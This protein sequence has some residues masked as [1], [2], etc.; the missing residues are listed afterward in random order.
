MMS[1][2]FNMVGDRELQVYL[3]KMN[4]NIRSH[5]IYALNDI[6]DYLQDK[7][8]DKFGKYHASWPKLKRASVIA[9]YRRRALRGIKSRGKIAFTI[10]P[11]DPLI[12]FGNLQK[13]IDKS[14]NKA[15]LEATIFSDNPYAAVHEYGYKN[16]PSRSYMRTTLWEEENKVID[17]LDKHIGKFI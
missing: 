10:G 7:V 16:I 17:I 13:S 6:A 14:V 11:D 8:K 9:K 5:S 4:T 15:A 12:L 1:L 3:K 2:N